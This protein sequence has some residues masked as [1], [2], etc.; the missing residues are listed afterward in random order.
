MT[1]KIPK[2]A[3][4]IRHLIVWAMSEIDKYKDF[5]KLC[6]EQIKKIKINK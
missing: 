5:I 1:K 4:E 6:E 3:K 2:T